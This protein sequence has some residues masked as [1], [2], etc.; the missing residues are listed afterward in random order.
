MGLW[1]KTVRFF[2]KAVPNQ[3]ESAGENRRQRNY[4]A[5]RPD[6]LTSGWYAP[7]GTGQQTDTAYRATLR[8][9]ARD[10]ERNSDFLNGILLAYER[11]VVG[12]G[13]RLQ[14]KTG[15]PALDSQIETL[16]SLWCEAEHCDATGQQGFDELMSM[17]LQRKLV[18]GGVL[19]HMGADSAGV[20]PLQL[21][22]IEV[23]AL[24]SAEK[25]K[26]AGNRVVDGVEIDGKGRHVGYWI[27]EETFADAFFAKPRFLPAESTIFYWKRTRPTQVR[28]ISNMAPTLTR[29]ASITSYM[30]SVA[31]KERINASFAAVIKTHASPGGVG[32]R[33][34]TPGASGSSGRGTGG[35]YEGKTIT[36]GMIYRLQ[37]GEDIQAITPPSSGSSAADYIRLQLRAGAA[38]Q[39][40]SYEAASRDLSQTNYSSGRQGAVED[41]ATF[42]KE[43]RAL[44]AY[45][46]NR[47]YREFIRL[48]IMANKLPIGAAAYL[49][50]PTRYE[51]HVWISPSKPWIDPAKEANANKIA[52]ETHQKTLTQIAA[53]N[54]R[55]IEE[56]IEE[57]RNEKDLL[58]TITGVK[59]EDAE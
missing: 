4:D 46:M 48:S 45:V 39:G 28:E 25:P 57:L 51:R 36:P 9:R 5:A 43:R 30:E 55:D 35:D 38:G 29:I 44:I 8:N 59:K 11:N 14:A 12:A 27:R 56:L 37:A 18:D 15:E 3:T 20:V 40:V 49:K 54:G 52:L 24:A 34:P 53:E 22:V 1:E 26:Y 42:D 32:G 2:R 21:Q 41:K 19:I 10:L 16:W 13:I 47:I 31:E 58:E 6:R 23:D 17:V 50:E 7:Y 33:S